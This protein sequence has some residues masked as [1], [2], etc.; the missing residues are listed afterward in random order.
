[1]FGPGMNLITSV[2]GFGMSITFI[3]FVCI[4]LI[5]WRVRAEESPVES[6]IEFRSEPEQTL[7]GL[8]PMVVAS[9]PT[10]KFSREAF[11]SAE[12]AQCS[13]CL[14]E[15]EEKDV[16]RIMPICGH[17]FHLPC[18]DTWL[19]KQSTCPVCRL[20]LQDSFEAKHTTSPMFSSVLRP[21]DSPEVTNDR[22]NQFL[23]PNR[24]FTSSMIIN[25]ELD[26]TDALNLDATFTRADRRVR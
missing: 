15:Y 19:Q 11:P 2:I 4:R 17:N 13:I 3:L 10:M 16:L 18:I 5:C 1:M 25:L 24:E 6:G 7:E 21:M 12:G 22:S 8:E 26:R 20:S 23:L 14:G 9:F